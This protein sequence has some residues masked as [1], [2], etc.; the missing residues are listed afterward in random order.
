MINFFIKQHSNAPIL[1]YSVSKKLFE[2]YGVD[3]NLLE[4]AVATFSMKSGDTDLFHIANK[5]AIFEINTDRYKISSEGKYILKYHFTKHDTANC[6]RFFGE[7]KIDILHPDH[8]IKL[9]VP[10]SGDIPITITP[11]ITKTTVI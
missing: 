10:T 8:P 2:K 7:F 3:V 4:Y 9:T 6:G 5:P 1:I 11:S